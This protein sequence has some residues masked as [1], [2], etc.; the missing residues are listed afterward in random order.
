MFRAF[1]WF[2]R[3]EDELA[4]PSPSR[5][6]LQRYW[7]NAWDDGDVIGKPGPG[8]LINLADVIE[9]ELMLGYSLHCG[10]LAKTY[11]DI[12]KA[13]KIPCVYF[14]CSTTGCKARDITLRNELHW[15]FR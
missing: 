10:A 7:P 11:N 9:T 8:F 1:S 5:K 13:K 2:Q 6:M 15:W 12:V 4:L 3:V 14:T